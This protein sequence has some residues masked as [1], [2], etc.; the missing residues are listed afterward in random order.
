MPMSFISSLCTLKVLF[1]AD[2]ASYCKQFSDLFDPQ[3]SKIS[4]AKLDLF[5]LVSLHAKIGVYSQAGFTESM[6]DEKSVVCVYIE[7]WT[8]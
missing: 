6:K 3:S 2:N 5:M 4:F 1:L 7:L 8:A